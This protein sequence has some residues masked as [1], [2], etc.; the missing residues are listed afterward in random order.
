MNYYSFELEMLA[1]IKAV[2]HF[3]IYLYDLN[4]MVITDCHALTYALKKGHLNLHIA[5]WTLRLQIQ[6]PAQIKNE[7]GARGCTLAELLIMSNPSL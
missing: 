2:K 7:N 3:H 5:R 6:S 4:F 1:V